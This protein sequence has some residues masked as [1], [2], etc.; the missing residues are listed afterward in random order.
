MVR[1]ASGRLFLASIWGQLSVKSETFKTVTCHCGDNCRIKNNAIMYV[2]LQY[3]SGI[4]L[5][6]TR[7]LSPRL[8]LY[9]QHW[10]AAAKILMIGD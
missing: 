5:K 9:F 7:R 10:L 6:Q 4:L 1:L 2:Y 3:W 8:K